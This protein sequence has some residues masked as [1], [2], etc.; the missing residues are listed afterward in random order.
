[1]NIPKVGIQC[2]LIDGIYYIAQQVEL[3]S[4]LWWEGFYS[5]DGVDFVGFGLCFEHAHHAI[6]ATRKEREKRLKENK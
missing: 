4:V 6:G 2:K 3:D 1:M 5:Q